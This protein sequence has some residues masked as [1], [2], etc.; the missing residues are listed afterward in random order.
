MQEWSARAG[1]R[2]PVRV[3]ASFPEQRL[4]GGKYHMASHSITLYVETMKQQ[5]FLLFGSLDRLEEYIAVILAHELGHAQD[6][7]LRQLCER[8]DG[9]LSDA[10]RDR[11]LLQI[12]VNAWRYARQLLKDFADASTLDTIVMESLAMYNSRQATTSEADIA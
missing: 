5:C 9:D 6:G 7:D 10:E 2:V 8:L 4:V 1:S 12:E 3:E 11:T